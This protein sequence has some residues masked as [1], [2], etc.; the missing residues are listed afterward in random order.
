MIYEL[1]GAAYGINDK[2]LMNQNKLPIDV[3]RNIRFPDHND[4]RDYEMMQNG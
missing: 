3:D 2:S 1:N 4:K